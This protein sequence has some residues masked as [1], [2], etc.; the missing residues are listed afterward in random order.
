M[1]KVQ[2]LIRLTHFFE[3]H[4]YL[5]QEGFLFLILS[6]VLQGNHNPTHVSIIYHN[7]KYSVSSLVFYRAY[8]WA[9]ALAF[10]VKSFITSGFG[11]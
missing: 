7:S 9:A 3:T 8:L 6:P 1:T 10:F 4:I 11:G 5:Q 2:H